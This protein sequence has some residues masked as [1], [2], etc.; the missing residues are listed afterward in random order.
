MGKLSIIKE[1]GFFFLFVAVASLI[2][3][4]CASE[5]FKWYVEEIF[6][7][8]SFSAIAGFIITMMV[9]AIFRETGKKENQNE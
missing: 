9:C 5:T 2:A 7:W 1:V 3:H 8:G 4:V 6:L